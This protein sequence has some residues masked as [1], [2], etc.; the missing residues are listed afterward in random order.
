MDITVYQEA[1][2]ISELPW[3]VS[4]PLGAAHPSLHGARAIACVN[5]GKSQLRCNYEVRANIIQSTSAYQT[6]T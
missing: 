6:E 2:W 1:E 3:V 4:L 5:T